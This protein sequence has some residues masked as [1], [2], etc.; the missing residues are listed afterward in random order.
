MSTL[1]TEWLMVSMTHQGS[2]RHSHT[3]FLWPHEHPGLGPRVFLLFSV[4]PKDI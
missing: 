1:G 4:Q 3:L 2:P